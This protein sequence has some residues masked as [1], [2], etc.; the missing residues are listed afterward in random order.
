MI[1]VH[2]GA[3]QADQEPAEPSEENDPVCGFFVFLKNNLASDVVTCPRGGSYQTE[4]NAQPRG[5][6]SEELR[7]SSTSGLTN[8]T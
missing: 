1:A 2:E 8:L 4:D 6:D 7:L 5:S 3:G